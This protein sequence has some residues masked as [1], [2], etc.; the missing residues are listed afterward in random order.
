[1]NWITP[2]FEEVERRDLN[3]ASRCLAVSRLLTRTQPDT[4]TGHIGF[5]VVP[6]ISACAEQ[7]IQEKVGQQLG[8]RR[9]GVVR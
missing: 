8:A 2:D 5:P 4:A 1:V 7:S 3:H 9:D 6:D